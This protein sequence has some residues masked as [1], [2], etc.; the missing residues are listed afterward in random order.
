[1]RMTKPLTWALLVSAL[2][3][4]SG[5]LGDGADRVLSIDASG[6]VEGL[7]FFDANGDRQLDQ[8]D[9]PVQDV[10]IRLLVR[11]TPDTIGRA[12]SDANGLFTIAGLPVGTYDVVIDTATVD[13][14]LLVVKV[15][16]LQITVEPDDSAN[17][18][19][20]LSFE[21]VSVEEAR[22]LPEGQRVFVEGTALSGFGTFGDQSVHLAGESA[23]IRLIRVNTAAIFAGDSV[24]FRGR[25]AID[26]GQ[27]VIIDAAPFILAIVQPLDPVRVTTATAADADAGALDAAL[28][29]VVDATI[30][31]RDAPI[32]Q[33]ITLTVD[34]GS[35]PL[36][37]VLDVD[38]PFTATDTFTVGTVIDA[39]GVLLPVPGTPDTW[40]LKPRSDADLTIK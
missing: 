37:L 23:A 38:V 31:D 19:V 15:D 2:A 10:G 29:E 34:D 5:C 24:R 11:S 33:D 13:D 18:Q 12:E 30:Q 21:K 25:L 17:S 7:V 6:V 9:V 16:P 20:A 8:G 28:V 40:L 27:P 32:G 14:T 1:M 22:T 26:Q 35:G 36:A 39:A 3:L 4:S